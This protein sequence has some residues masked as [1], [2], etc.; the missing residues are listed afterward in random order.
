M[1]VRMIVSITIKEVIIRILPATVRFTRDL[2]LQDPGAA[3]SSRTLATSCQLK[4]RLA[5]ETAC[6][7][8]CMCT[9]L[10]EQPSLGANMVSGTV[11]PGRL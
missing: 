7:A 6:N 2:S 3:S 11:L 8:G 10:G 4:Y 5:L 1:F 9:V